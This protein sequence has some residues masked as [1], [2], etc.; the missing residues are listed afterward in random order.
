MRY[1][2]AFIRTILFILLSITAYILLALGDAFGITREG[3]G[4]LISGL[5]TLCIRL[6]SLK[7]AVKGT[8]AKG[9]LLLVANHCSYLDVLIIASRGD[10]YFTPKS[11]VKSWPLIG[12]LVSRFNVVYVDRKPGRTKE[13]QASLFTLLEEG[14]RVCVFPE[15]TTNDG[16]RMLPFKSSLFSLAENWPGDKALPV[17]PVT[18]VYRSVNGEPMHNA[19]WPKVAWYGDIDILRHLLGVFSLRSMQAE[20]VLHEP[21]KLETGE[22]RKQLCERAEAAVA[23]AYPKMEHADATG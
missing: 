15:A 14:G 16:R 20:L 3:K 10:I 18:V 4:R 21:L 6:I 17:Q 5:F 1:I 9:P 12:P 8:L 19:N 2:R 7:I 13:T 11:D 23:S 22:S